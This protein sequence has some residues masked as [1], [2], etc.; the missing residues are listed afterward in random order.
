MAL[1][2]RAHGAKMVI[3]SEPT[4]KRRRSAASIVDVI[5]DPLSEKVGDRCRAV[6]GDIGVDYVFDCAGTKRASDDAFDA[7]R[8]GGRYVNVAMW[9]TSVCL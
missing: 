1:T 5:I 9:S 8:Y 2:L 6:T 4:E 3:L 7:I